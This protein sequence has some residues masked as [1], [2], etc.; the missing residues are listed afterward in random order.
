M[1]IHSA[2]GLGWTRK[3]KTLAEVALVGRHVNN[4]KTVKHQWEQTVNKKQ[5]YYGHYR[6]T[7]DILQRHY[8]HPTDILQAYYRHAI[9]IRQTL[10][11]YYTHTM[12]ILWVGLTQKS[13]TVAFPDYQNFHLRFR[14]MSITRIRRISSFCDSGSLC[15]CALS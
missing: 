5:L 4:A 9:N 10:Q 2:L 1:S 13:Q 11:A 8:R 6:D 15:S 7:T 14:I 12:S 3:V